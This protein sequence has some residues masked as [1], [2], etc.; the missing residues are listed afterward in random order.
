M[1]DKRIESA[2]EF[3]METLPTRKPKPDFVVRLV[4]T[5]IRPW[6]IEPR[7]HARILEAVQR[8]IEQRD[9]LVGFAETKDA[10]KQEERVL[11]LVEVKAGSVA[12]NF[13]A[14]NPTPAL[15]LISDVGQSIE[16]PQEADWTDS[17]LS[18]LKDLTE[19]AKSLKCEIEFR[20][21]AIK[22][23]RFGGV[24][25]KITPKTYKS[26]AGSA[27]I[28]GR[29]SVFAKI[30]RVGGATEMHC[31]IRL[32]NAPRKMVICRVTSEKLVRTLGKYM[33]QHV[34]LSG[35]AVWLRHSWRLRK[36]HIDAVE[37]PK[38]GSVLEALKKSHDAGGYAWDSIKDPNAFLAEIRG[39]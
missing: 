6:N 3:R 36:L 8:L 11:H 30:E 21:P 35:T 10:N 15:R 28:R 14:P 2:L 5:D 16:E 18:S 20:E 23:K 1:A 26:I 37:P 32:P 29:T 33:Y 13:S 12:Y 31:G 17:S 22:G 25:A 39:E 7:M 9:D 27:F 4:A 38:K 24:I 34:T 19:I